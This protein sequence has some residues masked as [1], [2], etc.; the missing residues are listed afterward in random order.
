LERVT[1]EAYAIV[2]Y[3]GMSDKIPNV[4]YYDSTGQE[5]GFSK[6]FSD[7]RAR[8]I[9]E[10]VSR[11]ISEQYERAK[12]L[13]K[14]KADGHAKLADVLLTSEV[15]FT[16]DVEKIFGKRQWTSRTDEILAA[17][18][19]DNKD[20]NQAEVPS[21]IPVDSNDTDPDHPGVEDVEPVDVTPPPYI[22]PKDAQ[23]KDAHSKE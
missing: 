10:E 16:E 17:R 19:N 9:D 21:A 11:I 8:T 6:P 4:S 23:S 2:V 12:E 1:K 5:Y 13:L 22:P 7:E 15:I 18:D 3:Y 20:Q 14:S